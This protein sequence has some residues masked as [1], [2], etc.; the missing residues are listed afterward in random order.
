VVFEDLFYG[1]IDDITTSHQPT[2]LKE[3]EQKAERY[4][5]TL[6]VMARN[7]L[8]LETCPTVF[9]I[10]LTRWLIKK[11]HLTK[12]FLFDHCIIDEESGISLANQG[13]I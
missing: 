9:D 13:F 5:A 7:S 10:E 12:V 2:I 11:L 3:I 6:V 4:S 1:S 8:Q